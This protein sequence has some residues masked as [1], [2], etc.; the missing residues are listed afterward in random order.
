MST[1]SKNVMLTPIEY[2]ALCECRDELNKIYDIAFD[3][4]LDEITRYNRLT[5]LLFK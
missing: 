5:E 2:E 1:T 4:S 3:Q